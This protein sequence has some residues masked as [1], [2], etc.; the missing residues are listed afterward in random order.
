MD[1]GR[2]NCNEAFSHRNPN[3]LGLGRQ[4]GQVHFTAFGVFS[5]DLSAPIL[6]ECSESLA[7]HNLYF[8]KKIGLYVQIPHIYLELEF[9]PQKLGI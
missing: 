3:I 1:Y 4:F 6:I 8:Y 5:A 2:P 9:G 7:F